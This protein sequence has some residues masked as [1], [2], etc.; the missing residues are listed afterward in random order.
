MLIM[1]PCN[2]V[3][4]VAYYHTVMR[5]CEYP[6]WNYPAEYAKAFKRSFVT[7]SSGSAFMHGSHTALGWGYDNYMIGVIS[8]T[9]YRGIVEKL[10]A[11]TRAVLS[12][13]ED[14][15]ALDGITLSE[16]FAFFS[17]DTPVDTWRYQVS[18]LASQFPADYFFSFTGLVHIMLYLCLPTAVAT[19]TLKS[20]MSAL[21]LPEEV[22]TFFNDKYS[23][24]IIPLV[25]KSKIGLAQS[26]DLFISFAGMLIKV[27]WAFMW[28]EQYSPSFIKGAYSHVGLEFARAITPAIN[29]LASYLDGIY[30]TDADVVFGTEIYPGARYCNTNSPHSLWHQ[31]SADC[32]FD[33]VM[34]FDKLYGLI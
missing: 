17:Y 29:G 16:R 25:A 12:L 20:V 34:V 21:S 4:N 11:S 8:Y 2:Y 19:W 33:L 10:G 32:F 31:Q 14:Y 30:S 24:D 9:A 23:P 1:E 28:Q 7:L 27:G 15:D 22:V 18:M 6:E 26:I 5:T 13:Q 3:S